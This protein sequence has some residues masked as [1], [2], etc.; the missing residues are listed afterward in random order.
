M[1]SSLD[2]INYPA[3]QLCHY[4]VID[5]NTYLQHVHLDIIADKIEVLSHYNVDNVIPEL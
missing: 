5:G 4:W 3:C 1:T 2:R